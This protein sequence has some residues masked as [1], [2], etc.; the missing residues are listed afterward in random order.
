M[1]TKLITI[2]DPLLMNFASLVREERFEEALDVA[3]AIEALF[4]ALYTAKA[5]RLIPKNEEEGW[6]DS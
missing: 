5:M 1:E 4:S 2:L 3:Q 6:R